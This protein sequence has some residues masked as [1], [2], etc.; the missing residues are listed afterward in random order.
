LT[1]GLHGVHE[2]GDGLRYPLGHVHE[3]HAGVVHDR[4]RINLVD[5]T[6]DDPALDNHGQAPQGEPELVERVDLQG[7]RR[8][9]KRATA[10]EL[11][12]VQRLLD[13]CIAGKFAEDLDA[14]KVPSAVGHVDDVSVAASAP[15]A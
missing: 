1:P 2:L 8:L 3:L 5:M 10:T 6:V 9:D 14:L 11:L 12:D 7:E 15:G 4:F 13:G